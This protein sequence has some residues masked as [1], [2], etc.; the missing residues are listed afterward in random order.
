MGLTKFVLKRPVTA[1]LCV[2][3]LVVFGLS[4]VASSTLEET[5][6]INMPIMIVSTIYAGAS[7]DDINELVTQP[8]EDAVDTLSGLDSVTS[9]SNE[10]SSIVMIQYKY[11]TDMDEAYL[12]LKKKMDGLVSELPDDAKTPNIMEINLSDTAVVTMS[13]SNKAQSNLYNYV[14]NKIVPEF[15]KIGSVASVDISGGQASYVKVELNAEK[16][17]QY[18]LNLSA[19]SQAIA[20]GDFSYP[21]GTTQ[22][23]DMEYSVT[24]GAD[25]DDIES[26]KG[27]PINVANGSVVQLQDVATVYEA[28]EDKSSISR[29]NGEDTISIDVK[30]QQSS[31][32]VDVSNE[33]MKVKAKLE[34]SDQNLK[35]TV[36]NDT[37][38]TIM[39]SLNSVFETLILAII[40]SMAIIYLFFGDLKASLIVG[41]SIPISIFVALI[42]MNFMNFSLNTIT[43][44]ALVLGVGLMVDNSIVVLESCFRAIHA[45]PDDEYDS[46]YVDA[47][48]KGSVLNRSYK[49]AAIDGTKTV[50]LAVF[51][52]TATISVVFL[53]LA[54]LSGLTGQFF[55]PL[56]FTIV[57]CMLAS[58]ISAVTIVPLCYFMYRP[59]EKTKAPAQRPI[60]TIQIRYRKLMR[61]LMPKRKLVIFMSIGVLVVSGLLATQLNMELMPADDDGSISVTIETRPGASLDKVDQTLKDVEKVIVG[62]E[63]V[64]SYMVTYG[65]SAL[66]MSGSSGATLTAYLKD[67]VK[68]SEVVIDDWRPSMHAIKNAN[69]TMDVGSSMSMTQSGDGYEIILKS[70]QYDEL[71]KASDKIVEELKTRP[72]VTKVHSTLENAAP[73]VKISVDSVKAK[74]EGLS[75][76][77]IGQTVNNMLSGATATS[78]KVNGEDTDVK[79]EFANGEYDTLDK[80]QGI[81][82]S[83]GTGG[84]VA[85]TDVA[86]IHYE[87]SP[88]TISR[89]NKQ[90]T[91]TIDADYTDKA[92]KK[93]KALLDDEV[94]GKY[95]SETVSTGVN[96]MDEMMSEEFGSLGTAMLTALFLV[97]VVMAAQFESPRYSLMIM[98]AVPLALIGSFLLLFL[99]NASISMTSLLGFLMLIGNVVNHGILYVDTARQYEEEMPLDKAL[100]EAGVTRMRP[101]VMTALVMVLSMIPLA[102]DGQM[103]Q[104]MALVNIG[105]VI[106]STVLSMVFLP[107][108]YA[109]LHR[110]KPRKQDILKEQDMSI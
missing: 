90:Y 21:A 47:A 102:R 78:M 108:Y 53:P 106:S 75:P 48:S 70:T 50:L 98:T 22:T 95:M 92:D 94:A 31:S 4:S 109:M 28:L 7:P 23:G 38:D 56:G 8:V 49:N 72:E 37:K 88:S 13:V 63:R 100:I 46:G 9:S 16:L 62:D 30:K 81:I 105:G 82:L 10:N 55:K 107:V 87:D 6:E 2:L 25:Y 29:Y 79:V 3:C 24:T 20:S 36:V 52:S 101:I 51:A 60:R 42:M 15:E 40:I 26:L 104:G 99:M 84:S 64:D 76:L 14:D 35:I 58:Y 86:N 85:L 71:K 110:K 57:F 54:F 97:F 80:V 19:V 5:P 103:M 65:G 43:M 67:K 66:S 96:S 89:E 68:D 27:I 17:N 61:G 77:A 69:I 59:E 34:A 83:T 32:A 11:G 73:V 33:V 74:A 1:V 39:E 18:G 44:G 45:I 91:V 12:D 41:T 93:T